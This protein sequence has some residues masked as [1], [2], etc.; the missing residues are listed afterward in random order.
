MYES[1]SGGGGSGE[2]AVGV[3]EGGKDRDGGCGDGKEVDALTG[4][5][6][7]CWWDR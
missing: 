7:V 2:A 4:E 6:K 5:L 1:F 3:V